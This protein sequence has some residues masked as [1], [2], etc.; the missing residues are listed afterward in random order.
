MIENFVPYNIAVKL[1]EKGFRERCLAYYDELDN[2]GVLSNTAYSDPFSP[3]QI[4]EILECYNMC[5]VCF[6]DA[7][8]IFQVLKWLREEK[9]IFIALNIGYCYETGSVPFYE[10]PGMKPILKGYY[11]G[12]W[13]LDD[14]NDKLG[15]SE[16]YKTYEEAAIAGIEYVLDN[17][18]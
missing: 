10:N 1:N 9:K 16:Y 8:T 17:L 6:I 15:H 3:V 2:I 18:I 14:L 7:P 13:L 11:Y 4:T 5:S 12:I